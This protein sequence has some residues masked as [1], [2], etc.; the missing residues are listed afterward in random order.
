MRYIKN[1]F[2]EP[3]FTIPLSTEDT[4]DEGLVQG[5]INKMAYDCDF[6]QDRILLMDKIVTFLIYTDSL[7]F[8]F[9]TA[10]IEHGLG[11]NTTMGVCDASILLCIAFYLSTKLFIYYFLVEKVVG[12]PSATLVSSWLTIRSIL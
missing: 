10:I 8:T 12:A 7:V 5:S 1:T 3:L 4:G 11:L 9:T 6:C 2:E